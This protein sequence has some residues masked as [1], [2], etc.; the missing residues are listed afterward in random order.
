MVALVCCFTCDILL[1]VSAGF[2]WNIM[3]VA[4]QRRRGLALVHVAGS[5]PNQDHVVEQPRAEVLLGGVAH[6]GCFFFGNKN[7][8]EQIIILTILFLA[9]QC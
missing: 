9:S 7:N 3:T 2:V 8:L 5:G 1:L 4:A 6:V